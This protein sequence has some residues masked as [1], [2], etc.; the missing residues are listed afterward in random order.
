MPDESGA[1][2]GPVRFPE[3]LR[4]E[5]ASLG[6]DVREPAGPPDDAAWPQRDLFAKVHEAEPLS[7]LCIS[8]GGIR[9]ATFALG[10]IQELAAR[11]VLSRFDYLS[12][13]SGGGY[14]GSWLTA[15]IHRAGGILGVVP[16]LI[17]TASPAAEE[18]RDADAP[19][20][21]EHLREFNS[22]LTP[23]LGLASGDT[24]ALIAIVVRNLLLNWLV[25]IPL[26]MAALMAPRIVVSLLQVDPPGG[27]APYP[28]F[29]ALQSATVAAGLLLYC[30]STF[31]GFGGLPS[32][33]GRAL[34]EAQ[35]V[36][37]CLLPLLL[38]GLL[39][40][41]GFWWIWDDLGR[42]P[43]FAELVAGGVV[44][45]FLSWLAVLVRDD[46]FRDP[47]RFGRRLFGPLTPASLI[48][49]LVSGAAAYVLTH[50]L[51][52][53]AHNQD[54]PSFY[55]T[56]APA[57][58]LG[59]LLL[60]QALSVGFT[61]R[62]LA[63]PDREWVARS[64][65]YTLL[66]ILGWLVLCAIVLVIP[67]VAFGWGAHIHAGL[68]TLGALAGW[69]S[70]SSRG[71]PRPDAGPTPGATSRAAG[72]A[73]QA[74]LPVFVVFLML[75]LTVLASVLLSATGLVAAPFWRH[76][77]LVEHTSLPVSLGL[78]AALAAAAL[79]MG[80][81]ININTFSLHAM[82]R[83][84]LVRAYLAASNTAR[85][86]SPFTGF[87]E[88][89]DLRMADLRGQRPLHV[90]NLT[91][92]LVAGRRLAWQQRKAESFTVTPLHA[93][94]RLLGYRDS[95][96]YGGPQGIRLG[97]AMTISGA[98][99]SPNM[100]Y[101]SSPLV[102]FTM[103]LFNARLGWWLGNPGP[104]GRDTWRL[105]GPRFAVAP[106]VHEM[107]GLTDDQSPYS[108]LSDGGHFE[109]LALYEMVL[110]RCHGI[111]VLDGG[112]DPAFT[113]D[114]L[115]N[116]LRKIRIDLGVP[117]EF[118]DA[119]MQALLARKARGAAAR[120]RYTAVDEGG[121]DGWLLYL[122]PMLR[123]D[124]PPDVRSY[125]AANPTFPHQTTAN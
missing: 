108:Y 63:E 66:A 112:C 92:N 13:V 28:W 52:R 4:S 105:D 51:F 26:L 10:A 29:G 16:R 106:V 95:A 96:L 32:L 109:N 44:L 27:A 93:G 87:D 94:S 121:R 75:A 110:R 117:I 71:G 114:D 43:T 59:G 90:L 97:T 123:G 46:L 60:G 20:P 50:V 98:A 119:S 83:D 53:T 64:G 11:G 73:R 70:S 56:L 62:T 36:R 45:T 8:G 85:R 82:Y 102:S 40:V 42:V 35:F 107:L 9:S 104:A 12:T 34:T 7:A 65:G 81:Y 88:S 120:I 122:K 86:P 24:W 74:A 41:V 1:P 91:L 67:H 47:K 116:A 77:E 80:R 72:F 23:R 84:R 89:D 25:L 124:E 38:A 31:N 14:V 79:V 37:R 68:A 22:Y 69:V 58:F 2:E 57:L 54:D 30:V 17:R 99:A 125:A 18:G 103:M 113:Y 19:D 21:V 115:G 101:N 5:Y 100:G 111:V 3:A 118:D 48:F 15:W 61:S 78:T 33:G 39:L 6:R 49:G 55:A 76:H